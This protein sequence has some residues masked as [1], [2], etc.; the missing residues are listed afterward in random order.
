MYYV[1]TKA[2]VKEPVDVPANIKYEKYGIGHVTEVNDVDNEASVIIIPEGLITWSLVFK[3]CKK[4]IWWMSVDNYLTIE[5]TLE[6]DILGMI[7]NEIP[8]HLV[9]SQYAYQF[10]LERGVVE[11]KILW[12][13][14]YISE[15]FGRFKMPL[16]FRRDIALYNPKKG[17]ELIKPLM[18]RTSWLKW[19]PLAGLTE[20]QM[21]AVMGIAKL[22]VDFG[23]H[24]G[25][26]RIPREAASGGCCI[27]TNRKGSAAFYEDVPIPDCYK[28]ANVLEEYERVSE[29]VKD[30]CKHWEEHSKRLE[31]YR[32]FI[33]AEREKFS[34]DVKVF[35]K[36]M[37]SL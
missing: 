28:I 9:Q 3:K 26:D 24:P 35:V 32:D 1:D 12:V 27:I 13:S 25:K 31:K 14:D 18:K 36:K 2:V 33:S 8:I 11:E 10:L 7:R 23:H 22:Y 30:I 29:L 15:N 37:E 4:V 21:I 5:K 34:K 19:I 16:E 17:L 6:S 20:E